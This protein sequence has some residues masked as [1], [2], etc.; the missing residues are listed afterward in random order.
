[1]RVITCYILEQTRVILYNT[2]A[3]APTER[4]TA[5]RSEK[6]THSNGATGK[7][8]PLFARGCALTCTPPFPIPLPRTSDLRPPTF[9]FGT[10]Q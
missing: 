10:Q 7:V 9:P 6:D 4:E 1:M 5:K 2:G 3:G 8:G